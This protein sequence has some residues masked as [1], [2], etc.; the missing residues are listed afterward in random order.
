MHVLQYTTQGFIWWRIGDYE[1]AIDDLR[2]YCKNKPRDMGCALRL[3]NLYSFTGRHDDALRKM[4]QLLIAAPRS[5]PV[6]YSA[7]LAYARDDQWVKAREHLQT[8]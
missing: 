2:H 6:L 8:W 7:A 1:M 4:N 3:A 5:P